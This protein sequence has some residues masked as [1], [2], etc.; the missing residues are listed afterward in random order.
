M[1]PTEAKW[2]LDNQR[3]VT[4]SIFWLKWEWLLVAL[5]LGV[6]LVNA[7]VSPH[8]FTVNGMLTSTRVF[9][10]K[11]FMVF[12]MVLIIL[13]G[14][15]DIS[16]GSIVALASVIMSVAYNA[17][18]PM[19][20]AM[21]LCLVVGGLCGVINGVLITRFKELSAVI[22]T[23]STMILFRGVAS[24]ILGNESAGGFPAWY[25]LL[26]WGQIG[27][28]PW[29]LVA[30]VG[31]GVMFYVLLH[32]STFG[33]QLYAM[34]KNEAAS[35]FAGVPVNRNIIVVYTLA[36]VMAGVTALFLTSR[37]G[38]TRPNIA[39]GFELEVIAMVALGGVSTAGGKGGMLGPIIAVFILGYIQ[40]GL[41]LI[42]IPAQT[43]MMVVGILLITAVA[44]TKIKL[45]S[46]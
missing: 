25:S 24:I 21:L 13:L 14:K 32:H 29:M 40:F 19:P 30:F 39:Q 43:L 6:V 36:G 38:S 5:L 42:N 34:G 44:V 9:L 16:V 26:G 22:L 27:G 4:P 18:M 33:R 28:V 3:K 37:M 11:S 35:F 12:P 15:I 45:K 46:K 17:G 2:V 7:M 10:D 20:M 8:F 1:E 31:F 23:L 41:G